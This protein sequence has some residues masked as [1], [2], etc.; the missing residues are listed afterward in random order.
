M[1]DVKGVAA[2]VLAAEAARQRF[3]SLLKPAITGHDI[4][5]S[6]MAYYKHFLAEI[7]KGTP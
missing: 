6:L 4:S 5:G 2:A 3:E 1:D 7:A